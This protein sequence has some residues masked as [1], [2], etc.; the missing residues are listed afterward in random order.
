M[1]GL[2]GRGDTALRAAALPQGCCTAP[3]T[4]IPLDG[5]RELGRTAIDGVAVAAHAQVALDAYDS[6]DR[7]PGQAD[8]LLGLRGA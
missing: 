5:L 7:M 2:G 8:I 1:R 3:R 6:I 4:L